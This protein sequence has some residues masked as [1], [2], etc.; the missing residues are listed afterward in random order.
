[1]LRWLGQGRHML[2][3]FFFAPGNGARLV[4]RHAV[5]NGVLERVTTPPLTV[6]DATIGPTRAAPVVFLDLIANLR[7]NC[8]VRHSNY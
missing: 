3:D 8:P 5:T 2:L 1:M 4:V 6:V 7:D